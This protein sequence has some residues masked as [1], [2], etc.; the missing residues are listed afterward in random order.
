M[1]RFKV[2][3]NLPTEVA[4]LLRDAGYDA[5]TVVDQKMGGRDD[6]VIAE[7]CQDEQRIIVSLDL[8]FSDIRSYSPIDFAG[9]IVFRMVKQNK[10]RIVASA[11]RV[12][13]LLGSEEIAGKLWV[14]DESRVRIRD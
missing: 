8:D 14:V 10:S 1:L 3:E 4:M 12:I 13:P 9:I 7:I 2:D 11:K 5:V 6:L